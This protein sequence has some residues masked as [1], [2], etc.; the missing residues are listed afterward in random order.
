MDTFEKHISLCKLKVDGEML[1]AKH[2]TFGL[3][4]IG[5]LKAKQYIPCLIAT[6]RLPEIV[7]Q[8]LTVINR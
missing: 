2:K 5:F 7:S 6:V 8:L 1:A 3:T 4:N